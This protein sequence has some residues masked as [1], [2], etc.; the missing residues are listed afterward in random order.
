[1]V[2]DYRQIEED[3]LKFW[4]ENKIYEKAKKRNSKG[5]KFYFLQGPPYTSGK[6][7]IGHA[8]NNCL[9]DLV[10]RY[11]RMRGFNVWDKAG[12]DM[13]GLPTENAV[14]KKLGIKDK[15]EIEKYGVEKFIKECIK[16]SSENAL[17][18]NEDLKRLGVWMDFENAYW[19][20][21]NE[22]IEGEWWLIKRAWEQKRLYK[23]KKIMHWCGNCE[24]S[25]A[26][27]ELEYDN[28]KD[29][30]IF[31]KFKVKDKKNEYLIIWT[32]T[33]WT[34]PFNLAIMVNPALDYVKAE[35]ETEKGKETWVVAKALV[36]VFVSGLLGLKYKVLEEFKG[37][38]LDGLEY[39]HPLHEKLKNIYDDLKKNWKRMH[40]VILSEEYVDTSSGSGLVHCAPG[41]GP[42]DFEVGK[43]YGI[44]AFNSIDEKGIFY[45][46]NEFSGLRA[47]VNDKKFV[48]ALKEAGS[49]VTETEVEHEYAHCWRCRK[50]VVFRATEQWFMKIEDLIPKL[51]EFNKKVKWEPGYTSKNYDLWIENLKDNGIT[52]QRY[53]GCPVPIWMC[54]CGEIEVIGSV[55]ELRKNYGKALPDLHKPWIDEV[56]FKCKKCKKEMKRIPDVI[57]VWIDAGTA[58][59]NCLDFPKNKKNMALWP[60]DFIL[61]ATEQIKLWFSMLQICSGVGFGKSCY[62]NVYCHGMILDYQGT[63]MSKSLGNIISPYEVVDKYGADVLRYYICET[64]AGENINFNWETVKIKQKNLEILYNISKFILDLRK[65]TNEPLEKVPKTRKSLDIEEK[66]IISM[67]NSTIEKVTA[68]L[69]EYRLDEVIRELEDLFLALSRIYIKFTREKVNSKDAGKVLYAVEEVYKDVLKMFSIVCPFITEHL[70]KKTFEEESVHVSSWPKFDKKKIDKSLEQKFALMMKI[71]EAGLFARDKIQ[72]GLK[73][74]LAKAT[75]TGQNFK[76]KKPE[77]EVIKSQLN[78]KQLLY[79]ESA[80]SKE[81]GIDFDTNLTPELEAEGYAREVSRQIQA[82]R[83]QLGLEKKD[84]IE[85]Y[86]IVS[87]DFKKILE[88]QKNFIKERTGAKIFEIVTTGKERFKNKTSFKVKE[89]SGEIAIVLK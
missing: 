69:E 11:K 22:F 87:E 51:L 84:K 29:N 59:W 9:K 63:K 37:K 56:K 72:I 54:S 73:W 5:K 64:P 28:I 46:M 30:S 50:P 4:K 39:I 13:H 23:G 62:K 16:F 49:L 3:T 40:T 42:E 18:M 43:K 78:V 77:K 80:N 12:Y 86:L 38:K 8:W 34:I 35:V 67:K 74:P 76:L 33:P 85:L 14:Q 7:H 82:Y 70:Y 10:L 60:A 2:Y 6:L 71:V 32:T 79:K 55:D 31:L 48:E 61:E 81:I 25:L 66:F 75:I 83:K 17:L 19:P 52:R 65:Q 1:M 44:G 89:K 27:H 57:D 15:S 26:K 24:T 36:N 53:W 58:S 21:K 20:I 88:K 68:L 45:G 41:C 47:K